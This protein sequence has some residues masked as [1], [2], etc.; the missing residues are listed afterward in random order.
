MKKIRIILSL[1]LLAVT[2]VL[3]VGHAEL[4]TK[5]ATRTVIPLE[6]LIDGK[7]GDI[8]LK[9]KTD[10]VY[11]ISKP[12]QNVKVNLIG[13]SS[14]S[15]IRADFNGTGSSQTPY[16]LSFAEGHTHIT[17]KNIRFD[18]AHRGRGSLKFSKN[19]DITISH[20]EFTGYSKRFG[21]YKTDSAI[22]LDGVQNATIEQNIFTKN[23]FEYTA[24][25][26]DLNRCITIQGSNSNQFQ[27]INNRFY[28]VNQAVV[29]L[30]PSITSFTA[31]G[32]RF[33]NVVD[34]ALYLLQVQKAAVH[35][36]T[37]LN[38]ADEAIVISGGDFQIYN[39]YGKNVKNKFLA[40]QDNIKSISFISNNLTSDYPSKTS[41][42]SAIAWRPGSS[43]ARVTNFTVKNNAFNLDTSPKNYDVFPIG[44]VKN[45]TFEN[46]KVIL[47]TL[48]TYQKLFSFNGTETIQSA[49]FI[50][51]QISVRSGGRIAPKSYFLRET[52][53]KLTPINKLVIRSTP[54]KGQLP[55]KYK[56]VK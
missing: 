45:W 25:L 47:Q 22:L 16:L 53:T 54:F 12:I 9:S 38:M 39:N 33:E 10:A 40:I 36:N 11:T 31:S 21:Y 6:P 28:Q 20:N 51:N 46:N 56:Y 50:D 26:G 48:E 8:H 23:G 52:A 55:F 15:E 37:F 41:R 34:N 27:L 3:P 35:H 49:L 2:V 30:A 32:N 24:K 42:P 1:C 4:Q 18:L 19:R 7:T 14:G 17:V 5:A 43:Q 44:N 29:A 13:A